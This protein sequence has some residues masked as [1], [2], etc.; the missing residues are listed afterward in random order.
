MFRS[1]TAAAALLA[2]VGLALPA[3]A[4]EAVKA[5]NAPA[6]AAKTAQH[7]PV[8]N[9]Q[10]QT[11]QAPRAATTPSVATPAGAATAK[12]GDV[13]AKTEKDEKAKTP[14]TGAITPTK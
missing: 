5:S 14:A 8:L 7:A 10:A 6:T 3:S 1:V 2:L 4:T 12:S 11:V 9:A 13:K